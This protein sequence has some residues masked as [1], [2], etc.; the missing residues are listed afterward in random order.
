MNASGLYH[1]ISINNP[2]YIYDYSL[3]V[4]GKGV[5]IRI[6]SPILGHTGGCLLSYKISDGK[7]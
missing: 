1:Q 6:R 3:S 4:Y 7:V 5:E 2:G